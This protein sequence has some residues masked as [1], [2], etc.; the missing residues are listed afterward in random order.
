[1]HSLLTKVPSKRVAWW[2]VCGAV[3]LLSSCATQPPPGGA[4]PPGFFHGL[5]HGFLILFSLIGSIFTEH[6][7]YAYPNAG[8]WYDFGYFLGAC[9]FLGGGGKASKRR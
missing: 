2:L 1:M 8:G 7:I 4:N 6:R 5:L 9:A 3:A